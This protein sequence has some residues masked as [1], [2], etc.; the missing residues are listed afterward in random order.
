L[1]LYTKYTDK[2]ILEMINELNPSVIIID[3]PLSLPKE[4]CCLE[5]NCECAVG[6]HF[7]QAERDIR[8]Y[9]TVLPLTFI[10]MKMLTLRGVKLASELKNNYE[11]LES[12][13]HTAQKILEFKDPLAGLKQFFRIPLNATGH[14]RC[15]NISLN[16]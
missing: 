5:K 8:Q 15:R 4:L 1:D 16:W 12:H 6:G 7:H 14:D 3:A 2:D 13:P 10:G 9:E 11:V